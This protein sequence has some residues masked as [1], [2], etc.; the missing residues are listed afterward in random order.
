MA[1]SPKTHFCFKESETLQFGSD[2]DAVSELQGM[3]ASFG[4]L[5]GAYNQRVFCE[6]TRRAVRRYQRFFGLTVDGVAGPVT[7]GR[8]VEPRCGVPDIPLNP[9]GMSSSAP[10]VLRGCKYPR[11]DLTFTFVNGTDDL[12]GNR[13]REIVRDA[14][15][16]WHGVA[17]LRFSEVA[18]N[19]SPLFRIAWRSGGHGDGS[20]FDGP[21]NTLA[22]AFFPPPC[23][24]PHAGDLHFDEAETWSDGGQSGF[25]LL[26]VAIHEIGH[27][28]GLSHSRDTAAIMYPTYLAN[29]TILASDDIEGIRALYGMPQP[30]LTS[31]RLSAGGDGELQRSADE[32]HFELTAPAALEVSIDGADDADFDLYVRKG[33]RPTVEQW[34][35]R[36]YTVSS[37]ERIAFP[38]EAGAQYFVMVRSYE[39]AGPFQLRVEPAE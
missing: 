38:V 29:R 39:G 15:A 21:G 10:Y 1:K 18:T 6:N 24:G 2:S 5:R 17:N 3:L 25:G 36:A 27:L 26:Q 33:E 7:L 11:N 30:D 13:E 14:F 9:G 16:A 34:D 35:Y 20:G 28:L 32:A 4:Y 37:D 12:P 31:L 23:G 19:E 22:H 8:I